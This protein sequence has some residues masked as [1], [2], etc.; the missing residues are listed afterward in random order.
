LA[1][2]RLPKYFQ[3]VGVSKQEMPSAAATRSAACEV[4]IERAMPLMPSR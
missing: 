4:G 2:S 1:S 3:P